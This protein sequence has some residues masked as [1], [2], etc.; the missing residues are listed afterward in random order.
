MPQWRTVEEPSKA[1]QRGLPGGGAVWLSRPGME[2]ASENSVEKDLRLVV[3]PA[4]R[5]FGPVLSVMGAGR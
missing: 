3:P 4:H 5:V 2:G 1:S